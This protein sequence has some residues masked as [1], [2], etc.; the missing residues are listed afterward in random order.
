[1]KYTKSIQV[2]IDVS[3]LIYGR[4][5]DDLFDFIVEIDEEHAN[6]D[7]TVKLYEYFSKQYDDFITEGIDLRE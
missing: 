4:G 3:E 7:L 6:W 1:M 5:S 2:D